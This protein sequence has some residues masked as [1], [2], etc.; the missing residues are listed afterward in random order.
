[1]RAP[2]V[3]CL[4][5]CCGL[6]ACSH[7]PMDWTPRDNPPAPLSA[8]LTPPPNPRAPRRIAILANPRLLKSEILHPAG[9]THQRILWDGTGMEWRAR[10]PARRYAYAGFAL[11]E[12][13][14]VAGFRADLRLVF[15]LRPAR[16]APF[17]SIALLDRPTNAVPT[18]SDVWLMDHTLSDG[19]GWTTVSIPLADFPV[20]TLA[21]DESLEQL[22]TPRA[23]QRELDW[24]A[25]REFRLISAGGRIPS[26]E[27]AIR[28]LRIQ[29]L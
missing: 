9:I 23:L 2:I 14:D 22:V 6:T 4:L 5:G 18:L 24:S 28:E 3:I 19:D 7:A 16:L 20:G 12:P 17:L 21:G 25:I 10:F 11:K 29:R 27:I 13:V 26:A 8:S 1:M 15:R